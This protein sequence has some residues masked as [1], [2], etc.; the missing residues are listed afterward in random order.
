VGRTVGPTL[1]TAWGDRPIAIKKARE[2]GV[3]QVG[4]TVGPTLKNPD[5]KK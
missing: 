1:K 2:A 3:P 4:R 5:A